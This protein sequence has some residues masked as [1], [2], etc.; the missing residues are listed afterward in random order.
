VPGAVAADTT[1]TSEH[2]AF[3]TERDAGAQW[4]PSAMGVRPLN[5][6]F[7]TDRD[8]GLVATVGDGS[9]TYEHGAFITDE[10]ADLTLRIGAVRALEPT[11]VSLWRLSAHRNSPS[12]PVDDGLPAPIRPF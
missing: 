2:G 1:Q 10:G 6:A 4:P 8:A 5:S 11:S 12:M 9:Q 7:T 3:T